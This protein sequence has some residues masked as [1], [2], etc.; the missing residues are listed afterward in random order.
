MSE[1]EKKK[2]C[3]TGTIFAIAILG[4]FLIVAWLVSLMI[5]YTKPAAIGQDRADERRKKLVELRAENDQVLHQL[6][7]QDQAKGVV[8]LPIERAM[9]LTIQEWKEPAAGRS[10]LLARVEKANAAPPKAPE[11]PSQYE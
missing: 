1:P 5:N 4:T 8:R 11:K 6:A 9:E 2:S 10:K 3:C 7:W